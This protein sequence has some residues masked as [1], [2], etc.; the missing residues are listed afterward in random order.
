MLAWFFFACCTDAPRVTIPS[1]C[2]PQPEPDV[3]T[4]HVVSPRSAHLAPNL[5][6]VPSPYI[7]GT[8]V[9]ARPSFESHMD[10][11]AP[12]PST[13]P[14]RSLICSTRS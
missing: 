13:Q 12:F 2:N 14:Q 7:A 10:L 3:L 4:A 8:R 11:V 1:I 9:P 6:L 5:D